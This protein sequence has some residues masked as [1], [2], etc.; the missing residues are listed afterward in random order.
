[1]VFDLTYFRLVSNFLKHIID[2][3]VSS[4][5]Y[6]FVLYSISMN[7]FKGRIAYVICKKI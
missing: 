3:K 4:Y 5:Y 2:F 1:M 6:F 7:T